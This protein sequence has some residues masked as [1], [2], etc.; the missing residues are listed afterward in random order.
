[1]SVS[2]EGQGLSRRHSLPRCMVI[3]GLGLA[4]VDGCSLKAVMLALGV[5]VHTVMGLI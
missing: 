1:M 3:G 4:G 2:D 5:L